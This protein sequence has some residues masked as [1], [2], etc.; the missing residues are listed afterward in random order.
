MRGPPRFESSRDLRS[1]RLLNPEA[2]ARREQIPSIAPR[3][4]QTDSRLSRSNPIDYRRTVYRHA[5][6]AEALTDSFGLLR[7]CS[8][9][10]Y[11]YKVKLCTLQIKK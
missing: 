1:N 4:S 8:A 9:D 5:L 11:R 7:E 10:H 2:V 6:Y 3:V